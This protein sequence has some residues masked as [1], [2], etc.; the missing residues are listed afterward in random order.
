MPVLASKKP[1][2]VTLACALI[3]HALLISLQINQRLDTSFVRVWI[4]DSLAPMEKLVDLTLGGSGNIWERY[5]ALIGVHDENTK[6]RTELD[7]LRMERDQR[8][9]ELLEAQRLRQMLDLKDS[10]SGKSVVARVIGR[11]PS[12]SYQTVTIDKGSTHGVQADSAV[13]TPDGIVGRVIYSSNFYSIVQLITDAQSAVGVMTAVSRQQ[14]I[15]KGTGSQQLELDYID[16]DNDLKVGDELLTSGMD[17]V[18]PKGLP[19][20]VIASVG[21]RRGLLKYVTIQPNVN[22]GRLEEVLCLTE[23]PLMVID[24]PEELP[25]QGLPK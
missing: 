4:L 16:D 6:L 13:F 24:S 19:A 25:A 1:V 3:G 2:W 20:G 15:I 10:V 11:A 14:G 5:I 22:L 7:Q 18:Y 8:N 17:R 12:P 21:E 9:Q 23:K